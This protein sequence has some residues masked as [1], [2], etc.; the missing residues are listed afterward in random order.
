[1]IGAL[2]LAGN[3]AALAVLSHRGSGECSLNLRG[4]LVEVLGDALGSVAVLAAALAMIFTGW[5]QADPV[6]S[7]LIAA[8]IVP[9]TLGCCG[10]RSTCY[11]RAPGGW[12][13]TEVDRMLRTVPGVCDVHDLH[14]WTITSG[15]HAVSA[16]LVLEQSRSMDCGDG[17][18]LDTAT[19]A[20]RQHFGLVHSRLQ[21]EHDD[22]AGHEHTC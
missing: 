5:R 1:M 18:V 17:S 21:V 13:P 8:L 3:L 19:H 12:R 2:G 14:V 15:W 11:W 20:L 16:H 9:R 6:A 10:K 22:H 7:L 4:T